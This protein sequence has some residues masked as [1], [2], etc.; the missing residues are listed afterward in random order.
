ME[1][2]HDYWE[3]N[4][5]VLLIAFSV[6]GIV[7]AI[8]EIQQTKIDWYATIELDKDLFLF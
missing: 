5:I 2:N 3:L 8:E 7:K 1:V 4:K 6:L